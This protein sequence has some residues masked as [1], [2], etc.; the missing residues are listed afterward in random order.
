MPPSRRPGKANS[1]KSAPRS[2]LPGD[3]HSTSAN[4]SSDQPLFEIDTTGSSTVRNQ[5]KADLHPAQ[6]RL[7]KGQQKPLLRSDQ[8][9]AQRSSVPALSSKVQPTLQVQQRKDVKKRAHVDRETKER[10]KRIVGR[11]NGGSDSGLWAIKSQK[12]VNESAPGSGLARSVA[13]AGIQ[14]L[15]EFD[16]WAKS[17]SVSDVARVANGDDDQDVSM[18]AVVALHNGK[19]TKPKVCNIG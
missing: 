17:A 16:A 11:D 1:K 12:Q 8:I 6:A 4:A 19:K 9:L 18:E 2:A 10:L 5:L 7:R 13:A 14:D 3:P 15:A